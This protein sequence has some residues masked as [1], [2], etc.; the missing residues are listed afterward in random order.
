M[1]PLEISTKSPDEENYVKVDADEG[2]QIQVEQ[3]EF[4]ADEELETGHEIGDD[5][6][7]FIDTDGLLQ[8]SSDSQTKGNIEEQ[9]MAHPPCC[10]TRKLGNCTVLS[11]YL[12][13]KTGF[14]VVGPHWCGVMCTFAILWG[15]SLYF[16][17]KASSIGPG[18]EIAT[19][20]F[21]VV[22]SIALMMTAFSD[23]GVVTSQLYQQAQ[24]DRR[25][26]DNW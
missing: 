24:R 22:C 25:N 13:Q 15:A 17:I 12:Y 8:C 10:G 20:V 21:T 4:L 2:L 9:E 23:P 18:T 19:A 6:D 3:K 5:E 11:P 14:G 1:N 16:L 7:G 26:I